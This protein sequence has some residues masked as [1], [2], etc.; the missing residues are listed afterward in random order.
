MKFSLIIPILIISYCSAFGQ[1]HSS[2]PNAVL[3]ARLQA[4]DKYVAFVNQRKDLKIQIRTDLLFNNTETT[5]TTY[6]DPQTAQVCKTLNEL[7]VSYFLNRQIIYEETKDSLPHHQTYYE[8]GK[9]LYTTYNVNVER[10]LEIAY[11]RN[12]GGDYGGF[13]RLKITPDSLIYSG[14]NNRL[15]TIY[16]TSQANSV[17]NWIKLTQLLKLSDFIKVNSGKSELPTDGSDEY[18]E[19]VSTHHRF[20]LLNGRT[21]RDNYKKIIPFV[22]AVTNLV[23]KP[24][25]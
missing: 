4:I 8:N 7:H 24:T 16:D 19:I 12:T 1:A 14:Q 2:K 3:S 23:Q 18:I 17:K 9:I 10:I 11:V 20:T 6:Q 5:T 13:T 15:H 21:D 22:D 25:N